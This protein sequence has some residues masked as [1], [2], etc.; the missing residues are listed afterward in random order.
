MRNRKMT[1]SVAAVTLA[2]AAAVSACSSTASRGG[3]GNPLGAGDAGGGIVVGSANF[4]ESELLA[5]I[6]AQALRSAGA[7]VTT[8]LSIGAREV[9]YPQVK[10]GAISVIPEYNGALLSTSVDPSSDAKSTAAVDAALKAKLPAEL[11]ILDSSPAAD[12]DAL[13]VTQ[14]T[15][16]RYRLKSIAD[17][18]PHARDLALGGPPEF[19]TRRDG[20][21][22]LRQTYGLAFKD[23]APLDTSG[24]I[25]LKAL[26]SGKVQV[27]DIFTTTP[28]IITDHL[29]ALADPK[30]NFAAQNVVPLASRKAM[31]PAVT[32][33]LNA[34]DAKLTTAALLRMDNAI[35]TDHENYSAVAGNFLKQEGL[36]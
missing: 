14:A 35:I 7:Q 31:T 17:L 8:K 24:P 6:Y 26:S 29:V 5:E 21:S 1:L 28:Q 15:A 23:F 30:G 25:T 20:V 16:D 36:G 9:Y 27:A 32:R 12:S 4:P 19:K 34:V 2:A 11:E 3:S 13:T 33:T 22:G 18:A 10:S